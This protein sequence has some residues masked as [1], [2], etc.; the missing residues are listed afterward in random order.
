MKRGGQTT[1]VKAGAPEQSIAVRLG[2]GLQSLVLES[3]QDPEVDAVARPRLL[4]DV[5]K[6]KGVGSDQRPVGGVFGPFADPALQDIDL[7]RR[8][9][10]AAF[11]GRHPQG[12]VLLGDPKD[13]LTGIGIA[14]DDRMF[15]AL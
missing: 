7:G 15:A 14:G 6:G 12:L 2:R 10:V 8:E 11:P 4:L 5:G 3:G 9:P 1:K 13:Q